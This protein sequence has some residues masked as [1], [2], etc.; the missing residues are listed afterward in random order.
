VDGAAVS[1]SS[2]IEKMM[3]QNGSILD[4]ESKEYAQ[5]FGNRMR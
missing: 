2:W 1:A 5:A 4:W 3:V